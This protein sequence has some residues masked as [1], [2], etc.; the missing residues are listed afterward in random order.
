MV[1]GKNTFVVYLPRQD[2]LDRFILWILYNQG[3]PDY[4]FIFTFFNSLT[5]IRF[6]SPG[7]CTV[8]DDLLWLKA[9]IL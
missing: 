6:E 1:L 2:V 9:I 5:I 4:S 8:K 7:V 3:M